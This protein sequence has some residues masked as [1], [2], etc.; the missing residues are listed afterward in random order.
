MAP[1]LLSQRHAA[2]SRDV[3]VV[4]EICTSDTKAPNNMSE[5]GVAE[6]WGNWRYA[7]KDENPRTGGKYHILTSC[8]TSA[9]GDVETSPHP[10]F[11]SI[12]HPPSPPVDS[13]PS[14]LPA[15]AT[16]R[17]RHL[18]RLGWLRRF[19]RVVD[20]AAWLSA[21]RRV[22]SMTRRHIALLVLYIPPGA[23]DDAAHASR[24]ML[25]RGSTRSCPAAVTLIVGTGT[26]E[27]R[28]ARRLALDHSAEIGRA[29]LTGER[30]Q[31]G[32]LSWMD[33]WSLL[34]RRQT[35]GNRHRIQ[36]SRR[37]MSTSRPTVFCDE[38]GAGSAV[39]ARSVQLFPPCSRCC[40]SESDRVRC[41]QLPRGLGSP[42]S[43]HD[44]I[45]P[46]RRHLACVQGT[47]DQPDGFDWLRLRETLR[48]GLSEA[49]DGVRT[50]LA[51]QLP[52]RLHAL[53]FNAEHGGFGVDMHAVDSDKQWQRLF[54]EHLFSGRP[55]C[56]IGHFGLQL[57]VL[58]FIDRRTHGLWDREQLQTAPSHFSHGS[59]SPKIFNVSARSVHVPSCFTDS[60]AATSVDVLMTRLSLLLA[61]PWPLVVDS[62]WPIFASLA[63]LV[64]DDC[65]R[66]MRR[67]AKRCPMELV[68]RLGDVLEIEIGA[69]AAHGDLSDVTLSRVAQ[70][71]WALGHPAAEDALASCGDL[72]VALAGATCAVGLARTGYLAEA[73]V[74]LT[75]VDLHIS[76]LS[77]RSACLIDTLLQNPH[78]W[79][80]LSFVEDAFHAKA[81]HGF[82]KP[83]DLSFCPDGGSPDAVECRCTPLYVHSRRSSDG[84]GTHSVSLPHLRDRICIISTDPGS[85]RP[86]SGDLASALASGASRRSGKERSYIPN[87]GFWTLTHHLNRLYALLHG[88]R[89]RRPMITDVELKAWLSDAHGRPS[90]RIQWAI[91]RLVQ[92]ELADP[93]CEYV[94]WLDSDAFVASSESLEAVLSAHGLLGSTSS[95]DQRLFLFASATQLGSLD[96]NISD[97]FMVIRNTIAARDLVD[98]WWDLPDQNDTLSRFR[99]D[100]FL[101]QTVMNQLFPRL[102]TLSAPPP[103]LRH[104]ESLQGSFVRHSGG[105][106]DAAFV[107]E[108][109]LALLARITAPVLH[110]Q[111]CWAAALRNN[112]VAADLLE[113]VLRSEAF[114]DIVAAVSTDQADI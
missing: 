82:G 97:H 81:P 10:V 9:W 40:I 6:A 108:L 26:S 112:S 20:R 18:R 34:V 75:L 94:V 109:R 93:S 24:L 103:P 86:L 85:D 5:P 67:C 95:S 114:E 90:R 50:I 84:N 104:F 39:M 69:R 17:R 87:V 74:Y 70:D 58:F 64:I 28:R 49:R 57:L 15:V 38:A 12:L 7:R 60:F 4:L 111:S 32:S 3:A 27:G 33:E 110:P 83:C 2:V 13:F 77:R 53:I 96:L 79:E 101:E 63:M 71:L 72:A 47:T 100:L 76:D 113:R 99:Q 65:R 35:R 14:S 30:P 37:K 62:G 106:K 78:L 29:T 66:G 46:L 8:G 25:Q 48:R 107:E 73:S 56:L 88:Y 105:I 21:C 80:V 22:L 45:V 91:V 54:A 42:T 41:T 43:N 59:N 98:L 44:C 19:N 23:S 89:F 36:P 31:G 68:L 61:V 11:S 52:E 16:A 92:I 102:P 55:A 51:Q 1:A